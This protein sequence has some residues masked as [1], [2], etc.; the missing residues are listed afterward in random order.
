MN[1]E[2]KLRLQVHPLEPERWA[3]FE[4]LFGSRGAC[5][6]CWCMWW[7]LAAAEFRRGKGEGNKKAMKALVDSGM[8]PGLLAYAG[9]KAVGWC[10]VEPREN[11]PRLGRSRVL[12]RVDETPVWSVVCFFVDKEYRGRGV[13]ARLLKAA[14]DYVKKQGGE[15]VEGYPV[16]PKKERIAAPFGYHGLASTFQKAGFT[17][18]ARRSETRPLMRL[19]L[20]ASDHAV[21]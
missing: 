2:T 21:K 19:Y 16:E 6:G 11:Y 12:A 13:T 20:R 17:E 1:K 7:K 15:V 4:R 10:A 5:G 18:C 14:V 3:D 8:A 9:N